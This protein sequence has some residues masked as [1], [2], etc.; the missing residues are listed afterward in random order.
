MNTTGLYPSHL[1]GAKIRPIL[2]AS[3]F[4]DAINQTLASYGIAPGIAVTEWTRSQQT[5]REYERA[6]QAVAQQKRRPPAEIPLQPTHIAGATLVDDR[7]AL[8]EQL[9]KQSIVAELGVAA[10]IFSRQIMALTP[11]SALHLIDPWSSERY[12]DAL[13][14]GVSTHFAHSVSNGRY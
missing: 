3:C 14:H 10:G 11:A 13:H 5:S 8:L 12:G 6:L 2:I 4:I 1:G 9:P 7:Q